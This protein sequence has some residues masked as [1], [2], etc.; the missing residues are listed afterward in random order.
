MPR[1][2]RTH[3]DTFQE[4]ARSIQDSSASNA[5]WKTRFPGGGV[6]I[7]QRSRSWAASSNGP[8]E[9]KHADI[10]ISLPA[11]PKPRRRLV[12]ST[13]RIPHPARP[14]IATENQGDGDRL[15]RT[16]ATGGLE[17]PCQ[18]GAAAE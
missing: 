14:N 13:A 4:L 17:C 12:S 16:S 15:Y 2:G 1:C 11:R 9:F 8:G 7:A 6:G 5:A 3:L 10:G 18:H